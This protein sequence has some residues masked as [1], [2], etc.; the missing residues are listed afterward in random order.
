MPYLRWM[1]N[2]LRSW[3]VHLNA[4]QVLQMIINP[5]TSRSRLCLANELLLGAHTRDHVGEATWFVSHCW[6]SP[7]A[8]VETLDAILLFFEKRE[9]ASARLWIDMFVLSQ[10][11]FPGIVRR[12][13]SNSWYMASTRSTISRIGRLVVVVDNWNSPTAL[14]RAW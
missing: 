7:N 8:F 12:N 3:M 1:R 10:H 9:E 14:Q 5:R 4:K 2:T 6:T 13:N 11:D